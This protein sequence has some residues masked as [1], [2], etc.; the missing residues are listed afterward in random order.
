MYA[1]LLVIEISVSS[2]DMTLEF[3]LIRVPELS[4]LGV[5]WAR[6]VVDGC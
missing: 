4:S 6:T 3:L 2:H 1:Y 5:Q